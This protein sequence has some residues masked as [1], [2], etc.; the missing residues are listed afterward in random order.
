MLQLNNDILEIGTDLLERAHA[1][2]PKFYQAA[3]AEQQLL[4][5]VIRDDDLKK[6]LFRFIEVLPALHSDREIASYLKLYLAPNGNPLPGILQFALG[7]AQPDSLRGRLAALATR[8]N[9]NRMAHKFV[10]ASTAE[11]TIAVIK[12]M[13]RQKRAFTIDLLGE[14]ITSERQAEQVT[15]TYLDLIRNLGTA[16]RDWPRVDPSDYDSTGQYPIRTTTEYRGNQ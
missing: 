2:E 9:A 8:Y 10:A 16:A 6:R 7:Y 13:R 14:A 15:Q 1:A 5:W 11:Q 12:R 4:N 3:W